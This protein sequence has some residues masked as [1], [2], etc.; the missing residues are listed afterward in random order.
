MARAKHRLTDTW[1]KRAKITNGIYADGDG[2]Y[3]RVQGDNR[4]WVYVYTGAGGK[5]REMGMGGYPSVALADARKRADDARKIRNNGGDPIEARKAEKLAASKVGTVVVLRTFAIVAE[6]WITANEVRW[7]LDV[8]TAFRGY[9][10]NWCRDLGK[11]PVSEI[12]TR[13]VEAALKPVWGRPLG[14]N[15]RGFIERVLAYA[16]IRGDRQQGLNPARLR[17]NIDQLMPA[18]AHKTTHHAALPWSEVPALCAALQGVEGMGALCLRFIILTGL[19]QREARELRWGDV[20]DDRIA[21]PAERYK[22][23]IDHV[24]PLSAQA[25][26]LLMSIQSNREP[27]GLVFAGRLK[28]RPLSSHTFEYLLRDLNVNATAHGFRTSL[29]VWG[30]EAGG[31]Q[32]DL[33]QRCLGHVVGTEVTRAYQRSDFFEAKRAV[34]TAWGSFI[35]GASSKTERRGP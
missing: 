7:T 12:E 31:F 9:L 1:L 28:N 13:D 32:D 34:F 10:R 33:M 20:L 2:L 21:I 14:N 26:D 29:V 4:S 6:E 19:R 17:D 15:V 27:A 35:A 25:R 5:R 3:M 30:V 18:K 11:M 16:M 23:R 22:T 24:V 8:A